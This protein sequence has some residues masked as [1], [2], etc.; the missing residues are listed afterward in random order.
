M[1]VSINWL[2]EFVDIK[3]SPVELADMLSSIGLEAE[4][5]KPF[6]DLEGVVI[7]KVKSVEKH[8]NADR[9]NVCSVYDGEK[10][11]KVVCGASNVAKGQIIA[12]AKV[13][14]VLPDFNFIE[15]E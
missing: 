4:D 5:L 11:Y 15:R 1:I 6:E 8:P 12:Y 9:L 7:G 3:E 2:K 13:G 14:S 10:N